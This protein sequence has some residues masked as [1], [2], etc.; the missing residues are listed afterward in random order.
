LEDLAQKNERKDPNSGKLHGK[1]DI[2]KILEMNLSINLF[3]GILL[4]MSYETAWQA[5]VSL[6]TL[7]DS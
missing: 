2:H 6:K 4:C 3:R 7:Q 1:D 5:Q